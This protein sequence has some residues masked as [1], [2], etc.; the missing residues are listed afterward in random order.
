MPDKKKTASSKTPDSRV[1]RLS[2]VKTGIYGLDEI[3]H[4]GLPT[5]RTTLLSGGPGTGKSVMALEFLYRRAL[6]GEAGIYV[7]FE[8]R[9]EALHQNALTFGWNLAS[10]EKAGKLFIYG[11]RIDP[12]V[13]ISGDFDLKG[14]L[15]ILNGK[16]TSMKASFIVIDA[17]DVLLGLFD[18]PLRE[19]NELYALNNWLIERGMT[20][21]LT[22]KTSAD[23]KI[24]SLYDFLDYMADCVIQ[25]DQHIVSNIS[26]KYLR[27]TKYRGSDFIHNE[28]PFVITED[29]ISITAIS[30]VTLRDRPPGP[31]LPSGVPELDDLLGGGYRR[32]SSIFIS[33]N[34]GTGKTILANSFVLAACNRGE[35]VLSLSF[36]ESQETLVSTMLSVGIDLRPALRQGRLMI[37][38]SMPEARGAEEHLYHILKTI[39]EFKP[40]H[41]IIDAASSCRRIGAERIAF[42]FLFRLINTCKERDITVIATNQTKGFRAGQE[43]SGIGLSSILDIII[44][45]EY[46]ERDEHLCRRLLVARGTGLKIQSHYTEYRITD[47]GIELVH[48]PE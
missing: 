36:E 13:T 14:L 18:K 9:T 17:L 11:A 20:V 7:T 6:E 26:T 39:N 40:K 31:L 15:A 32:N 46:F 23:K 47:R 22:A 27:V 5:N 45:L 1:V 44:F 25:L 42:D 4:G 33:G 21:V 12:K 43:I 2:K 38:A 35:K 10:L 8:E 28:C 30:R 19:R 37:I 3:L 41:I 29:G 16:I 34:P 24:S 48:K